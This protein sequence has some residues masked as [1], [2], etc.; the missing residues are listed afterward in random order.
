MPFLE[1]LAMDINSKKY[2]LKCG[3][4]I[5]LRS[6]NYI[7]D[8]TCHRHACVRKEVNYVGTRNP[9]DFAALWLGWTDAAVSCF[10]FVK[11]LVGFWHPHSGCFLR[12][13]LRTW[14]G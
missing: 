2:H 13:Y 14:I 11:H 3:L 6:C 12:P 4:W 1:I 8:S 10:C 5:S 9:S 7:C